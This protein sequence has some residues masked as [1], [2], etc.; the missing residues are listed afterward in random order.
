MA[1]LSLGPYKESVKNVHIQRLSTQL[2]A[3]LLLPF[4]RLICSRR[5]TAFGLGSRAVLCIQ[6]GQPC[7]NHYVQHVFA[8]GIIL[9]I[10]KRLSKIIRS[11]S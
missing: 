7:N 10:R 3:Q 8:G 4:G 1:H 9:S 11:A 2:D 6:Y 5:D